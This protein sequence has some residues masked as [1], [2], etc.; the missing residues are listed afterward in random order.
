MNS[1]FPTS[2]TT[3]PTSIITRSSHNEK[4][5]Q[6]K[7]QEFIKERKLLTEG[8]QI[9]ISSYRQISFDASSSSISP[10]SQLNFESVPPKNFVAALGGY[11]PRGTLR[12]EWDK[13]IDPI[14]KGRKASWASSISTTL[15][16]EW[17]VR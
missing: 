8:I 14:C 15:E 13:E 3:L 17:T 11:N 6:H 4:E 10:I 12:S 16:S 5:S 9:Q 7:D 2:T 1:T